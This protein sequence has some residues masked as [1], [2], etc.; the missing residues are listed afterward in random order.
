M[1]EEKLVTHEFP[2]SDTRNVEDLG[3]LQKIYNVN[4]LIDITTNKIT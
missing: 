4:A 3:K 1:A 2:D